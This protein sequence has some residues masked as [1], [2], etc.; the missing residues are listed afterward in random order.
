MGPSGVVCA[1]SN[2]GR[3]L[4]STN[5]DNRYAPQFTVRKGWVRPEFMSTLMFADLNGDD[6][7]DIIVRNMAGL[8]TGYA[9]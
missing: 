1:L 6:R 4:K 8:L 3:L 7:A 9:P 2:G 5:W